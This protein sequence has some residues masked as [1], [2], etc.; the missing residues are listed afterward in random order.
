MATPE[1]SASLPSDPQTA[2]LLRAFT[3]ALKDAQLV[4]YLMVAS[5]MCLIYDIILT[6]PILNLFGY[7][8]IKHID[9]LLETISVQKAR[10]TF[11]SL[12]YLIMRY[13]NIL[14]QGVTL[15]F[16]LRPDSPFEF[17]R[18]WF[19]FDEWFAYGLF[20]PTTIFMG[21]RTYALYRTPGKFNIYKWLI[22]FVIVGTS[23]GMFTALSLITRDIRFSPP[24]V[25]G[26]TCGFNIS[27][28]P[29]NATLGEFIVSTCFDF[30]IFALTAIR[31]LQHFKMGNYRI[32]MVI[33]RDSLAYYTVLFFSGLATLLL[34]VVHIPPE[35]EQLRAILIA[36]MK[37]MAVIIASRIVLNLRRM[38]L[39]PGALTVET[40]TTGPDMFKSSD[41][42]IA[43]RPGRSATNT[44]STRT[45]Y[46]DV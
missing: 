16:F 5:Y 22:I 4:N 3:I 7:V 36:P 23:I 19:Y 38:V 14:E 31:V 9:Q 27:S 34:Y 15:V 20:I 25:R 39:A 30:S 6:F 17:C 40:L 18:I 32:T 33:F 2:A 26:L 45:I 11:S 24:P 1:P 28:T 46:E 35:R 10:K 12:M 44:D 42:P 37:S 21:L 8:T 13:G 29:H 43:F 41:E